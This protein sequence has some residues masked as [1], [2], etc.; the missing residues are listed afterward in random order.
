MSFRRRRPREED[1]QHLKFIASL[2]CVS[3]GINECSDAAHLRAGNRLYG[4]PI[5]GMGEKPSDRWTLPLCRMCHA[6]QHG[7]NEISFWEAR[8]INPWAL[9][10][11]LHDLTG[12]HEEAMDVLRCASRGLV[13]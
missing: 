13:Q 12:E 3:C 5:T 6:K 9:C 2:P 1:G 7:M 4:K 10:Q 11:T 8:E